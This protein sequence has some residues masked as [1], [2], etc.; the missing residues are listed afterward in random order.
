MRISMHFWDP[1]AKRFP[2]PT[3]PIG[4][5]DG[6][7]KEVLATYRQLKARGLRPGGQA[8]AGQLGWWIRGGQR[9]AYLYWVDQAKKRRPMTPAKWASIEQAL[10][11]RRTCPE[12]K[13]EKDYYINRLVGVCGDCDPDALGAVDPDGPALAA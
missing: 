4:H 6:P 12:C 2:I 9:F 5:P 10:K 13:T 1:E 11:A 8:A 7:D 3:W